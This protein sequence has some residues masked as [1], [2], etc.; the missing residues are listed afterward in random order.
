M[1]KL[2][3]ALAM[4]TPVCTQLCTPA[5]ADVSLDLAD[6]PVLLAS[7]RRVGPPPLPPP[8][9]RPAHLQKA[10]LKLDGA[11]DPLIDGSHLLSLTPSNPSWQIQFDAT[12]DATFCGMRELH[13]GQWLAGTCR[14]LF[15]L[16][17]AQSDGLTH[18]FAHVG[19]GVFW[20]GEH[21]NATVALKGGLNFGTA[22]QEGLQLLGMQYPSLQAMGA[23]PFLQKVGDMTSLDFA[24]GYRPIHDASVNGDLTYGIAFNLRVPFSLFSN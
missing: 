12:A 3:L 19:V 14:D 18:K 5:F 7:A 24:L 11:G 22:I 15:Y 8:P 1:K 9:V 21:G 13:D 23:P 4:C 10:S 20:N 16:T 17:H 2:L 6:A